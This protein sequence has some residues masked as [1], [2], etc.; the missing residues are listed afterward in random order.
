MQQGS[1]PVGSVAWIA[2]APVKALGLVP[3][4]EVRLETFGVQ[5]NRAFYLVDEEGRM[6]NGKLIGPLVRV[7]PHYDSE[8]GR[9]RLDFPAG[10]VVDG[11]VVLGEAVTTDFW[12]RPVEGSVVEG[13]WSEALSELAGKALRLV[14]ADRPGG[15]VDRGP[16]AGV[17]LVSTSSLEALAEAAGVEKV[18]GRRFRMLFGVAD[19]PA[20][21]EDGWVGRR[22]RVGEG[23]VLVRGN[24]GRCAVT[25]QNPDTGVPDLDT[26]RV[27]GEYRADVETT[28]ARPFGVWGQVVEPGWVRLGDPVVAGGRPT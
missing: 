21:A 2:V 12:G 17:S 15:A 4:D 28:E 8:S 3:R 27:L 10:A 25:T 16:G 19:V 24:V 14:K 9:L 18:D 7:S 11:E 5:E 13:P 1:D 26:L 6:V 23:T 20:Y 22:V